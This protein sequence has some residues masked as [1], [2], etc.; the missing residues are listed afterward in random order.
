[1]IIQFILCTGLLFTLFYAYLQRLKSRIVSLLIML[2]SVG[3]VVV[4]LFPN[5]SNTFASLVGIG[6]GADLIIYC[7]IVISLLVCVNLQFKILQ[8]HQNL[9][10]LTRELALRAPVLPPDSSLRPA[11]Q[12]EQ[13]TA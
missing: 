11:K 6:R 4:V 3:G 9:T 13:H 5:A 8:I 1:M 7:W 12:S 2:V 10:A